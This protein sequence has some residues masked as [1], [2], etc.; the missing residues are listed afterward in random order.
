M[1]QIIQLLFFALF[2]SA[3][4]HITVHTANPSLL[5]PVTATPEKWGFGLEMG[6]SDIIKF[7]EDA[8]ARPPVISPQQSP[9]NDARAY[10]AYG[11]NNIWDISL[12][13]DTSAGLNLN[14]RLR[15]IGEN[16]DVNRIILTGTLFYSFDTSNKTGDQN[17]ELGP[18]GYNWEADASTS[19]SSFGLSM[20]YRT[21]GNI[22]LFVHG[23]V[24][25]AATDLKIK[26]DPGSGD[27][28]G[29][30]SF[31]DQAAMQHIGAGAT[32]GKDTRVTLGVMYTHKEWSNAVL[33]DTSTTH[34]IIK[35]E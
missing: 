23:G 33:G 34:A 5:S 2:V 13:I 11:I 27:P 9:S 25:R 32:L 1:K 35:I 16:N 20:G 7:T 26:Q 8:S 10:A 14:S 31:T 28:G 12:G 19:L 6:S 18:G 30:Y 15:F 21:S 3:C 22:L 29:N 17:G 4:S 24:G